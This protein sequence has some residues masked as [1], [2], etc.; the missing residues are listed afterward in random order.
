MKIVIVDDNVNIG[1]L[2]AEILMEKGHEAKYF[3]KPSEALRSIKTEQ[4]DVA[5]LDVRMPDMDG[6]TL[7][8]YIKADEHAKNMRI[9]FVSGNATEAYVARS[10]DVGAAG[11][12]DKNM[13]PDA[14]IKE[15]ERLMSLPPQAQ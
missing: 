1:S 5:L 12:I 10:N 14:L 2:L 7:C 13:P 8:K 4:Y 9:I 11:H 15:I 3:N 6:F